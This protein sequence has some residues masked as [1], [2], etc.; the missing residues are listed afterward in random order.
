MTKTFTINYNGTDSPLEIDDQPRA[1]T[2]LK[3]LKGAIKQKV[4]Q[5][6]PE[7]DT[8]EYMVGLAT[9]L[10]TKAPWTLQNPDVIKNMPWATYERLAEILGNEF[11][12]ERFL[13]PG[14]KLLYGRK[15][16]V[17]ASA[18]LTESTTSAGSKD[19]PSGT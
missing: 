14:A 1:G 18:L 2:I 12:L 10:I 3:I 8:D 15:L 11:P 19:S 5:A 7:Y 9:S 6:L 4:G 16:E 17:A 13:F